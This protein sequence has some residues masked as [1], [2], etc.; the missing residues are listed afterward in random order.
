MII[1]GG[2]IGG[3]ASALRLLHKGYEV[4][5][6]EKENTLGGRVNQIISN[7]GYRFD[8]SASILLLPQTFY[9]LFSDL[10]LNLQDYLE[11]NL[12]HPTYRVFYK[13]QEII[14][15]STELAELVPQLESFSSEDAA[16][17]LAWL[18]DIYNKYRVID[19]SFLRKSFESLGEFL[20]PKTMANLLKSKPFNS[21]TDYLKSFI[22][23][24][25][26]LNYLSFQAMFIG[27]NPYESSNLYTLLPAV[28]QLYGLYY[29]KGGMYELIKV[30]EKLILEKGGRIHLNSEVQKIVTSNHRAIGVSVGGD[31]IKGDIIL[32][33]ADVLY[34]NE[35]LLGES[36]QKYKMSCSTYILYLGVKQKLP[37]FSVHNLYIGPEFEK[38]ITAPFIGAV[39]EK[40]SLYVYMPTSIDENLAPKG[41]ECLNIMVRVPNLLKANVWN[42]EAK[43]GLKTYIYDVLE[44][45]TEIAEF[46]KVVEFESDFTPVDMLNKF[47][48]SLGSAFGV[49]P[50]LN[51]TNYF[52]P[53]HKS[54]TYEGLYYVGASTHPG[55]GISLVLHSA[56]LVSDIIC[57][58][59]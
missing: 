30:L 26:V 7:L 13:N 56:K 50:D 47:N 58:N 49:S 23:D 36:P 15:F 12:L 22:K 20:N 10:G 51:Q 14:D 57:H 45:L 48:A 6:F 40:P 16:G 53:H 43:E 35:C 46:E 19:E 41:C 11:M 21:T 29:I 3:L 55:T 52:R 28:S 38:N 17:Y 24:E 44:Q 8:L 2:G 33:N 18:T 32:A 31:F 34:V 37:K 39:P 54:K 9:E 59:K 4:E 27:M 25:R 42:T 5:V 1:I